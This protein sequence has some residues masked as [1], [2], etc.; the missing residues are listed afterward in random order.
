MLFEILDESIKSTRLYVKKSFKILKGTQ[1]L[2]IQVVE[3]YFFKSTFL[4][5]NFIRK[6][7]KIIYEKTLKIFFGK[8]L[9][10]I[11]F[12]V[13]R[14]SKIFNHNP[15]FLVRRPLENKFLILILV[16]NFLI[17]DI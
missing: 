5:L 10:N 7:L 11:Q 16:L 13:Q 3:N 12:V 9:T 6:S 1:V 8:F 17:Q 2:Y 4:G 15:L 14:F